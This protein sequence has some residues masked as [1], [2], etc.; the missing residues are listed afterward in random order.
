M[1][2]I[3]DIL[4]LKDTGNPGLLVKGSNE[5]RYR[6]VFDELQGLIEEFYERQGLLYTPQDFDR[7]NTFTKGNPRY[8]CSVYDSS[9]LELNLSYQRD[10]AGQ[11]TNQ[12]VKP[13]AVKAVE[14]VGI[15][16]LPPE[17]REEFEKGWDFPHAPIKIKKPKFLVYFNASDRNTRVNQQLSLKRRDEFFD[18]SR[19]IYSRAPAPR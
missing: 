11:I 7:P 19:S 9:H 18:Y 4:K 15:I 10:S 13:S 5:T 6:E 17:R 8:D 16:R 1:K 2:T 14:M 12:Q 3:E